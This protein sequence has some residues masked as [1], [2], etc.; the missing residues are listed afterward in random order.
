MTTPTRPVVPILEP[1]NPDCPIC[2]NEVE[3]IDTSFECTN[4]NC[5][6]PDGLNETG[7]WMDPDTPQCEATS[8][9]FAGYPWAA[10][11]LRESVE[12]CV[13]DG[14]HDGDHRS[15]DGVFWRAAGS[16]GTPA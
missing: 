7:E 3:F 8:Q 5:C 6:W 13:L 15:I 2:M 4:C 11:E 16:E 14:D 9:P 10:P 12:R 1:V